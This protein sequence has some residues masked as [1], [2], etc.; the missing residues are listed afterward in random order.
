MK[1]PSF[2]AYTGDDGR[3]RCTPR[4]DPHPSEVVTLTGEDETRDERG[5]SLAAQTHHIDGNASIE[6][7]DLLVSCLMRRLCR[8]LIRLWLRSPPRR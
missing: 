5:R 4:R 8:G 1:A 6:Q 2:V 7:T 3:A